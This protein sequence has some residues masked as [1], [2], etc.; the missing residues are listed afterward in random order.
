MDTKLLYISVMFRRGVEKFLL[1]AQHLL[2]V[3]CVNPHCLHNAEASFLRL[4]EL[5]NPSQ[6]VSSI[7][8]VEVGLISERIQYNGST[9]ERVELSDFVGKRIR[10]KVVTLLPIQ[11]HDFLHILRPKRSA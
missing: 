11:P 7:N 5:L 8:E 4:L 6:I 9:C 1:A 3:L 2:P 10:R